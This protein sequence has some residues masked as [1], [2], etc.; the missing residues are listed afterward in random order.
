MFQGAGD[1][2]EKFRSLIFTLNNG[3]IYVGT[4]IA[5]K[6][7]Y[8]KVNN[9][10][11]IAVAIPILVVSYLL[12]YKAN[13]HSGDTGGAD[14]CP[15][16]WMTDYPV[17]VTAAIQGF[18]YGLFYTSI[19]LAIDGLAQQSSPGR[20]THHSAA[21]AGQIVSLLVSLIAL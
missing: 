2:V 6:I 19:H 12:L 3:G 10:G 5:H 11:I 20:T 9:L 8:V 18:G 1:Q 4:Y 15:N 13:I 16:I 7:P 14:Q 21:F 17:L